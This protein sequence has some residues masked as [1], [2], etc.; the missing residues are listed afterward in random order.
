[1]NI[2][3]I[4]TGNIAYQHMQAL[5][6]VDNVTVVG[7]YDINEEV[8]LIKPEEEYKVRIRLFGKY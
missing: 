6:E 1:M 7:L 3:F 5:K 8:E 2:A 4:G